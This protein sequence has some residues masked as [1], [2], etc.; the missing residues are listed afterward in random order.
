MEL[1]KLGSNRGIAGKYNLKTLDAVLKFE[2]FERRHTWCDGTNYEGIAVF[3]VLSDGTEFRLESGF[4]HSDGNE[5]T[6]D[7]SGDAPVIG[8]QIAGL[9]VNALVFHYEEY[10][11]NGNEEWEECLPIT[12]PDW[13]VLRR[14]IEDALRKN[15]DNATL[16]GIANKLNCKIY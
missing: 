10:G 12:P 5:H 8:E 6:P 4:I 1:M 16:F 9:Q 13:K 7:V 3:A 15:T 2:P 11:Q 14:R